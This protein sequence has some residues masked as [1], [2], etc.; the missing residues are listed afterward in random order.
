[1]ASSTFKKPDE[2]ITLANPVANHF[3][4]FIF[5]NATKCDRVAEGDSALGQ[6]VV[7][8]GA[9]PSLREHAADY[10][11]T[12]D[13]VWGCNSALTW[14]YDHGHKVTHGFTVDQTPE[15]VN[16]WRS[17]PPVEYL[18]ASTIHPHLTDHLLGAGRRLTFFH[19]YVGIDKPPVAYEGRTMGFEDWMYAALYPP[20]MRVGSGLNAVTRAIDV[21]LV[22]GFARI[23][24]LGADCAIRLTA[25]A[26][27]GVAAGTPEH[28]AWLE[29][30]TEMHADG[31]NALASG[32]TGVTMGAEIDD[33]TPDD[34]VRPGCGRHWET[35]PDMAIS[36]VCLVKMARTHHPRIELVGDTLPN[37]LRHK[38][39]HFLT[40]L[41][42]SL[43]DATGQAIPLG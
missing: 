35:K 38:T 37:A 8:C 27:E 3:E 13:Q 2:F 34:T 26:P 36:A 6:T 23:V 40:E 16:E 10:C 15:M 17:V 7:I 9:G 24:V 29:A 1:M 33:G 42:P 22:M 43:R 25:P 32:A 20:T 21:A 41:M 18:V 5:G 19:N 11:P 4:A 31:G 12:A 28:R 39:D 14:L 30:H